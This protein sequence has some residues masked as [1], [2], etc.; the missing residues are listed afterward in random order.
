MPDEEIREEKYKTF[1]ATD[2]LE[3]SFYDNSWETAEQTV[4]QWANMFLVQQSLLSMD[5]GF[6]EQNYIPIGDKITSQ[7]VYSN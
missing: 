6:L 2:I 4:L 5:S 7:I 3:Y 1:F